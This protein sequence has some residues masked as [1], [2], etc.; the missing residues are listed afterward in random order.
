MNHPPFPSRQRR[1]HKMIS[2]ILEEF[3]TDTLSFLP[4][5]SLLRFRC[6]HKSW[7]SLISD[8]NFIKLHLNRSSQTR[9]FTLVYTSDCCALT[10]TV[11]RLLENPPIIFNLPKDPYYQF[12]DKDCVYIVGSCNG[13]LCLLGHS[14]TNG[15]REMWFR[16][17]NPA[18]RTISGK[19]GYGCDKNGDIGFPFNFPTNLTFGYD[20]S[21]DTY[22]V[23]YFDPSGT[24]VRVFSL[25]E[26]V[27]R[28][29]QDSPTGTRDYAMNVVHLSGN[30]DW[31]TIRNHFTRYDCEDISI[32]HFV[33]VSLD[34]GTETHT[35]LAPPKGFNEVPYVKPNL[36]VLNN[37]LCFSHDFKQTHMVIWKMKKFGAEESWTQFFKV[38]YYNLQIY[39]H[40]NDLKFVLMPLCLSEKSDTVVLI[41][42]LES[43]TILYNW[44]YNK[45]QRIDKLCWFND[46]GYVESLVS[47]C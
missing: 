38:N 22:K 30:V 42:N 13:L 6:V 17:W 46:K 43:K 36:S 33:I 8:P 39:D 26:N 28:N 5:K 21:T 10:F 16:C 19:L 12:K 41:S 4:V 35:Q 1:Q 11:F 7:N 27:W 2:F 34:L 3:I 40:F 37:C 25:R 47:Y 23:V 14:Y 15:Y 29:I 31:L 20:N 24:K 9:D 32:E 44:R 45:V 18:T